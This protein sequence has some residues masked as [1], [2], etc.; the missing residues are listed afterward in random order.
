MTRELEFT[1]EELPILVDLGTEAGLVNGSATIRFDDDGEW[2]VSEI[3][4]DGYGPNHI[5]KPVII[6]QE[7]HNW[8][9]LAILDQLENGRFKNHIRDAIEKEL[10]DDGVHR[11]TNRENHS[12]LNR[13]QQGV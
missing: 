13:A 9:Y 7:L 3:A 1:F 6:D 10:D 4:L 8:L 11:R 12:T 5:R 2:S